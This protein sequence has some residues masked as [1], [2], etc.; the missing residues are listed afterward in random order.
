MPAIQATVL[1]E[2]KH[3]DLPGFVVLPAA[4]VA[5]W[6]LGATTTIEGTID[7]TPLGRRSLL[8][9]DGRWFIELRREHLSAIGKAPGDRVE[10]VIRLASTEL[11]AELQRL[12]DT[13]KAAR[14][15]W[16]ARTDA[17][18][19]MLRE[20]I[21]SAKTPSTRERRAR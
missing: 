2:R 17:Q 1:I 5:P 21:L 8:W 6:K 11:P 10:L 19:R 3:P 14:A 13:D 16:D 18:K 4:K 7:G 9:D 12:I 20:E 15:R